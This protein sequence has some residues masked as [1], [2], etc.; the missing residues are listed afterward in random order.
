MTVALLAAGGASE[1][2]SL[3][4]L[5]Q[6]LAAL[7][8]ESDNLISRALWFAASVAAVALMQ[9]ST[10]WLQDKLVLDFASDASIEIFARALRQPYLTHV[11]R[12]SAELFAALE[13]MQRLVN[14]ALGP[15][16]VAT[17]NLVL[18]AALLIYLLA[19]AP[20]VMAPVLALMAA[21]Y[22][23]AGWLTRRRLVSGSS[24][25]QS[26]ALDR[27]KLVHEAQ[28]GYRDLVLSHGEPRAIEAFRDMEKR[29][30]SRQARDR[31]MAMAPR[32]IVDMIVVLSVI[33]LACWTAR[34]P[35]GIIASLPVIGVLALGI[36]RLMP[37]VKGCY[38]GWSQFH[39]HA[40]VIGNILRLMRRQALPLDGPAGPAL[41]F[42]AQIR[43]DG[44]RFAYDRGG[45]VLQSVELVIRKGE[46]LG[47]IG[48]S[49]GG[50]STLLDLMLGLI[51][52]AEGRIFIDET[53]L[54]DETRRRAWRRHVACV[55][56][57]PYLPDASIRSI[58]TGGGEAVD[59]PRME[60]ALRDAGLETLINSL[61]TG[62]D[63]RVGEAG[64]ML[65]GGQR[66]RLAIARALYAQADVL[67]LDEATSQL[68]SRTEREI[69]D[70]LDRLP[71]SVTIVIAAHRRGALR[72]CHRIVNVHEGRVTA[73]D[74]AAGA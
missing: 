3:Y 59:L 7:V 35:G 52:P 64:L 67:V 55:S 19:T 8:G 13:N 40:A 25:L 31:F 15:L 23:G 49:G 9:L 24:T 62:S 6:F 2:A 30:R 65:S 1:L 71:P 44:V 66:Q 70:A 18:A 5:G 26:L 27:L 74:P 20:L 56:Q 58:V 36:Q 73:I 45:A 43:M 42:H 37:L 60:A 17:V 33:L 54:D 28:S 11:A 61:P 57:H 38:T 41:P 12:E 48:A 14:G 32:S 4:S 53:P 47:V 21:I 51:S 29:Y 63:S 68:D 69:V 39:A 16:I 72:H 10:L 34:S 50:K 46:R 22:I